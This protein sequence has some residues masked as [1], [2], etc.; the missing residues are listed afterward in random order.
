M[1]RI[2][3]V[4]PC[5]ALTMGTLG[6]FPCLLPLWLRLARTV[7]AC[8]GG[9]LP[10]KLCGPVRNQVGPCD[11]CERQLIHPALA[12]DLDLAVLRSAKHAGKIPPPF[13]RLGAT[14]LHLLTGEASEILLAAQRTVDARRA[15]LELVGV[16]NHVG[17]IQGCRQI[18]ADAF[19]IL[20]AYRESRQ[21]VGRRLARAWQVRRLGSVDEHTQNPPFAFAIPL[22]LDEIQS[23]PRNGGFDQLPEHL[24]FSAHSLRLWGLVGQKKGGLDGPPTTIGVC[25]LGDGDSYHGSVLRAIV[26]RH[27]A[28]R[29]SLVARHSY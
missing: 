24:W 27:A 21:D 2:A 4:A 29:M 10:A 19:A 20:V 7:F 28:L 8:V 13:A 5:L 14:N 26:G 18:P 16:M 15:N 25:L 9:T 3:I 22:Q 12:I 6:L 17:H 23:R 1:G 11:A